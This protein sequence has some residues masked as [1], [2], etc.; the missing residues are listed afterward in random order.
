[1]PTVAL[2]D[3]RSA[4]SDLAL[5]WVEKQR[6]PGW[7]LEIVQAEMPP[8]GPPT[9]PEEAEPHEWQ[10]PEPRAVASDAEF[11]E[12]V[13]LTAKGDPRI[14]LLRPVDLLVI[15]PRGKGVLKSLHLGSVAEWIIARPSSPT[16]LVRSGAKVDNVLIA[17]DG[18]PSS[19]A[20]IRGFSALPWAATSTCAL[21]VVDDGRVD[22]A[23]ATADAE[24]ILGKAGV[25][26]ESVQLRGSPTSAVAGEIER[27]DPDLVVLGTRGHT[28]MRR[29]HLGSTAGAIVRSAHCSV[30]VACADEASG[31]H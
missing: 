14:V 5:S 10:P 6:W 3:D 1:M 22:V 13:H 19:I 27:R 12:V 17:H 28:G 23:K 24:A 4:S 21:V 18:S 30:L 29:V 16:V 9:P 31:D 7:R 8:F 26:V 2:G 15:G 20:A 25:Q 11:A